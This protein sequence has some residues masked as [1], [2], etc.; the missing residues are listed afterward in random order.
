MTMTEFLKDSDELPV[1]QYTT[2]DSSKLHDKIYV[3]G[4]GHTGALGLV[5]FSRKGKSGICSTPR[6]VG[7]F[8]TSKVKDVACGHGFTVFAAD[9]TSVET[10]LFGTGVNTDHQLGYH[11]IAEGELTVLTR[12]VAIY[13]PQNIKSPKIK[14]VACGRAHTIILTT[15]NTLYSLGNNSFGQCG[16]PILEKKPK[17]DYTLINEIHGVPGIVEKV[18]CGQDHTLFLLQSGEVYACGWSADGQTGLGY[19][20][21]SIPTKVCGDIDGEKIV[22]ISSFSDGVLACNDKGDVFCWGNSEYAQFGLISDNY[23]VD[24][25]KRLPLSVGKVKKV[26]SGGSIC[27]LVN[28]K[29]QVYVWGYGILGQGPNV[30]QSSKPLLLPEPLFGC[31][32]VN[33]DVEVVSIYAGF[34]RWAAVNSKGDLFCWGKNRLGC[35]GFKDQADRYFPMRVNL[36]VNVTKVSLGADHTAIIGRSVV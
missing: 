32:D 30:Q 1:Y 10:Q 20:N 14:Q 17:L 26:A 28:D 16:V 33:P 19:R 5:N 9:S 13:F 34:S 12:P 7:A 22:D 6:K 36:P 35:L 25:P 2:K 29:G 4:F 24:I 3:W 27:G 15:D 31:N 18:V 8:F 23:Q 11:R 21:V